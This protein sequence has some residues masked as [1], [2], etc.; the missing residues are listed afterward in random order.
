MERIADATS[1]SVTV[2]YVGDVDIR[3]SVRRVIA[4]PIKAWEQDTTFLST[5]RSVAAVREPDTVFS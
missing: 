3:M 2:T 5:G 4:D 1:E